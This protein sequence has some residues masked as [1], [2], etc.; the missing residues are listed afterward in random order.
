MASKK[1]ND[2]NLELESQANEHHDTSNIPQDWSPDYFPTSAKPIFKKLSILFVS[3]LTLC[4]F[5]G[6]CSQKANDPGE[7]TEDQKKVESETKKNAEDGDE[8]EDEVF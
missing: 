7:K 5:L 1:D 4:L 3:V 2:Q 8:K 6:Y